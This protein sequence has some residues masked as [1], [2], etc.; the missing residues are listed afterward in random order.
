MLLLR[1]QLSTVLGVDPP[2]RDGMTRWAGEVLAVYRDGLFV[3]SEE[4]P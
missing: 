3:T 1:D 2:G 4:E